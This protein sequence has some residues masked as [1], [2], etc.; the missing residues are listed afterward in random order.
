MKA[1]LLK[2]IND[3]AVKEVNKPEIKPAEVLVKVKACGVCGSDIPRAY[4]TGA[5]KSPIII[6]HEFAGEIVECGDEVA[7]WMFDA[8]DYI[9]KRVGVFP[10]IP[11]CNCKPCKEGKFELCRNYDYLG[12]RSDGGFAEYVAVPGENIIELPD[13]VSYEDAAM[14]EPAA[15]AIHAIRQTG[16]FNEN[17][18]S[19]EAFDAGMQTV[20]A[21]KKSAAVCGLGTIGLLVTMHLLNLN[22]A[23]V[24]VIGNRKLQ[25]EKAIK[26]GLKEENYLDINDGDA[27]SWLKEKTGGDGVD[28]FFECVGKNETFNI[29][30]EC[31]APAGHLVVVGNPYS[32]VD[33]PKDRYWKILRNQLTIQGTWNSS[34]TGN[35]NDDWHFCLDEMAK[36][37]IKPSEL[38]SHKFSLDD[39]TKG[40]EIMRD[41]TEDYL[42]V[43]CVM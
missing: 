36:G 10:L 13:D 18:V 11:C 30:V 23:E 7:S 28:A 15:V 16:L 6:G 12:S 42:K 5:H 32:D 9:G 22:D 27:A 37:N 19:A 34:F 39:I 25:K 20:G 31:M 24:Y 43:M 8:S 4:K 1:L 3:I 17:L 41:K 38:I 14:L 33:L 26:L 40:M 35:F 2:D 29:G 21:G